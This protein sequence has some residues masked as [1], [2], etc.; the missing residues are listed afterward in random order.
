[1]YEGDSDNHPGYR[2]IVAI[3][4]NLKKKNSINE[5]RLF[6]HYNLNTA[7]IQRSKASKCKRKNS[8]LLLLNFCF[9]T[10]P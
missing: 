3:V 10:S 9:K 7:T 8:Q 1:M 2:L 6:S 5:K 4:A